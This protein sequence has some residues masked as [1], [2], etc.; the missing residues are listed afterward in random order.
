MQSDLSQFEASC[1]A[2]SPSRTAPET[3]LLGFSCGHEQ[4]MVIIIVVCNYN[5]AFRNIFWMFS[6][7]T[8]SSTMAMN[9]GSSYYLIRTF[10]KSWFDLMWSSWF[11]NII[12]VFVRLSNSDVRFSWVYFDQFQG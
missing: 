6:L 9:V 5:L 8:R 12:Y 7:T 10:I 11:I 1:W 4:L 3:A 2:L